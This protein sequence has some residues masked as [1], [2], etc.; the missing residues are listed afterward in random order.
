MVLAMM[1]AHRP[2]V[3]G[4]FQRIEGI[5]QIGKLVCHN[6]VLENFEGKSRIGYARFSNNAANYWNA[7]RKC[8]IHKNLTKQ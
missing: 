1:N 5:G 6:V 4:G 3:D 8:R 2:L 7:G